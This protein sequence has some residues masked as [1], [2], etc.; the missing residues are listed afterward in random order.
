MNSLWNRIILW[1]NIH[2]KITH[3]IGCFVMCILLGWKITIS[4]W[5]GIETAQLL[6]YGKRIIWDSF[7]DIIV[8]ALGILVAI[9]ISILFNIVRTV[10]I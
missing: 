7:W 4:Y 6:I 1:F 8:D 3:F 2:D 5:L 9:N 10:K